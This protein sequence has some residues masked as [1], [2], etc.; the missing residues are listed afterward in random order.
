MLGGAVRVWTN[1][2]TRN[3]SR[4]IRP[5][6]HTDPD[7]LLDVNRTSVGQVEHERDHLVKLGIYDLTHTVRDEVCRVADELKTAA[8]AET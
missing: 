6:V 1:L 2:T 5:P 8:S 4:L 7:G 3:D